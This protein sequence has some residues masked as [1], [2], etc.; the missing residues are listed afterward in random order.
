MIRNQN[1]QN[2]NR[3]DVRGI[4]PNEAVVL[5]RLSLD[6]IPFLRRIVAPLVGFQ[7]RTFSI[8]RL[9]CPVCS[10]VSDISFCV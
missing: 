1:I 4:Q 9:Q 5:F 7:G 8:L 2:L 3:L 6:V 10:V